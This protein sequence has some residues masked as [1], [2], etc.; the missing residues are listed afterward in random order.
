MIANLFDIA[1]IVGHGVIFY[2]RSMKSAAL[3]DLDLQSAD[4]FI[5]IRREKRKDKTPLAG[6]VTELLGGA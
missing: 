5:D 1:L 2:L 6:H 4:Q 3:V